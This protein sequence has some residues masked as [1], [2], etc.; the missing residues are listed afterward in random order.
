MSPQARE[1]KVKI[2]Y[3]IK[4]KIFCTAKDTMNKI[5]RLPTEWENIFANDIS[6]EG[7]ISKIYKELL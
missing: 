3:Y 5:K 6:F 4:P 7:L 2:N 1:K